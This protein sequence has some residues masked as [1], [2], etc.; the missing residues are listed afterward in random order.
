MENG[1]TVFGVGGDGD[2][3]RNLLSCGGLDYSFLKDGV[4][5]ESWVFGQYI[6]PVAS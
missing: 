3:G 2:G 1:A 5:F 4:D 6:K